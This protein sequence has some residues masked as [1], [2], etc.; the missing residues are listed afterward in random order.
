[1]PNARIA[2]DDL[3]AALDEQRRS[4]DMSWRAVARELDISPSTMTRLS[5]GLRPDAD[6]FAAMVAWLRMP[7]DSYI[8]RDD[9]PGEQQRE[10]DVLVEVQALLRS[11]KDLDEDQREMLAEV[12]RAAYRH[13][14]PRA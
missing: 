2:V 7:A 8:T 14:Q 12:L 10:P 1:M 13:V 11:R 6:T 4:R 3:Y 5:N 9:E